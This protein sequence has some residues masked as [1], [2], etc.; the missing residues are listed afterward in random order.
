M[1][2]ERGERLQAVRDLQRENEILDA[3]IET[4]QKQVREL[5]ERLAKLETAGERSVPLRAVG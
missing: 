4:L 3:H 2:E 5:T 1:A